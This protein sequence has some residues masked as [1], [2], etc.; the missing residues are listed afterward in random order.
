MHNSNM[1]INN[2]IYSPRQPPIEGADEAEP[3][4][5]PLNMEDHVSTDDY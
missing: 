5:E 1:E 2:P 4:I 3:E